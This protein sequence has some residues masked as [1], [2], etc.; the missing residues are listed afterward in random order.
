MGSPILRAATVGWFHRVPVTRRRW[1]LVAHHEAV[2]RFTS[3]ILCCPTV[4]PPESEPTFDGSRCCIVGRVTVYNSGSRADQ[5]LRPDQ[6]EPQGAV[7]VLGQV[8]SLFDPV[9]TVFYSPTRCPTVHE[10]RGHDEQVSEDVLH[11]PEQDMRNPWSLAHVIHAGTRWFTT[12]GSPGLQ[13]RVWHSM[14]R[15]TTKCPSRSRSCG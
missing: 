10:D 2:F 6:Q 7:D 12:I 5:R 8:S 1:T 9:F 13:W 14:E 3:P 15:S 4:G 11:V